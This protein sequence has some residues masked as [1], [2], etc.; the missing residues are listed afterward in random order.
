VSVRGSEHP[1]PQL[2]DA[3]DVIDEVSEAAQQAA[4]FEPSD[5]PTYGT[6]WA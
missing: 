2:T 5:P 3:V 1:H 6:H 4:V